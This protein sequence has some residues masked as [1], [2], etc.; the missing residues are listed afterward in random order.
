MSGTGQGFG[1]AFFYAKK[2][3]FSDGLDQVNLT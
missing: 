2:F 3:S 1:P